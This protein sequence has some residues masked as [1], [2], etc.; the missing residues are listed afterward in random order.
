MRLYCFSHTWLSP[1]Q[2]GIQ[3]IHA[4]VE[5]A[6][7]ATQLRTEGSFMFWEWADKHKTVILLEGGNTKTLTE[8]YQF[9]GEIGSAGYPFA[10]FNEDEDSLDGAF[11]S[12]AAVIPEKIYDA[13][14]FI[15]KGIV[16]FDGNP[17]VQ[18]VAVQLDEEQGKILDRITDATYTEWEV[19]LINRIMGYKLA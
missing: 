11:T 18:K 7:I 10:S 13:A 5:L 17:L 16:G 2:K 14:S 8:L 1:Q 12:I 9:L 15:K 19:E 3:A 4:T 6:R